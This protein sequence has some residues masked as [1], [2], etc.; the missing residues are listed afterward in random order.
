VVGD[1]AKAVGILPRVKGIAGQACSFYNWY[2]AEQQVGRIAK[3][4]TGSSSEIAD[5]KRGSKTKSAWTRFRLWEGT[6]V[7]KHM[8]CYALR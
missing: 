8:Q 6:L 5:L 2:I 3:E 7:E 4:L 1:V